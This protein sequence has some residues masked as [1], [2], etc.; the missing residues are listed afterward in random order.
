MHLFSD[1]PSSRSATSLINLV[2]T[3]NMGAPQVLSEASVMSHNRLISLA[4]IELDNC[5]S[6]P[7][8]G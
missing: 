8:P 7:S 5:K 1:N 3:S 6:N 4:I 2:S